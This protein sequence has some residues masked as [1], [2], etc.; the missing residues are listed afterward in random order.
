VAAAPALASLADEVAAGRQVAQRLQAG[1]TS[2]DKLSDADFDHLGEYV[3]ERVIGSRAAHQAVNDRMTAMMGEANAERMHELMGRPLR[4]L[5]YAG[6]RGRD[7]AAGH[8]GRQRRRCFRRR[9]GR[10]DGVWRLRLDAQRRV[11]AHEPR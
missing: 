4:R 6:R 7:D 9:L 5:R 8:D 1:A 3:I 10:D 11:A 2:C